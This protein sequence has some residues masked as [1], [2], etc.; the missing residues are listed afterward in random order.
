MTDQRK[1]GI[2]DIRQM[3]PSQYMCHADLIDAT[4]KRRILRATIDHVEMQEVIMDGGAKN[5][6]PVLHFKSKPRPNGGAP[7]QP[8]PLVL[9]VTNALSIASVCGAPDA[10]HEMNALWSGKEIEMYVGESKSVKK[11]RAVYG[12]K[13]PALRIRGKSA[14]AEELKEELAHSQEPPVY[15]DEPVG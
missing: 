8:K 10:D 9:N 12:S 5:L 7:W 14:G 6:R 4:G 11:W 1:P 13:M 2:T 3:F 15:D